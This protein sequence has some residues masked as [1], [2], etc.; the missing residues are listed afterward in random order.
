MI[1]LY[2]RI[3]TPLCKFAALFIGFALISACARTEIGTRA[4][5]Y[6]SALS[7]YGNRE[8]LLNAVRASK[9]LPM[10]F[11][12]IGQLTANEVVDGSIGGD[13]PFVAGKLPD[14]TISPGFNISSGISN[15]AVSNLNQ[16][17]FWTRMTT[18]LNPD[19]MFYYLGNGWRK[20]LIFNLFLDR[21]TIEQ[22]NL[23]GLDSRVTQICSDRRKL[24]QYD[25]RLCDHI[26]S[27]EM[28]IRN[29]I[30]SG[31]CR[32]YSIKRTIEGEKKIRKTFFSFNNS[33]RNACTLIRYQTLV[34]KFLVLD[35][36]FRIVP[37]KV[38][39]KV[40]KIVEKKE[41]IPS[42]KGEVELS[43]IIKTIKEPSRKANTYSLKFFPAP[44]RIEFDLD[45]NELSPGSDNTS[46]NL[47]I[48]SPESMLFYLGELIDLQTYQN[49]SYTPGIAIAESAK[50]L[51]YF[52]VHRGATIRKK[53]SIRLVHEGEHFYIP[54]PD[55]GNSGA[56]RTHQVLTL[57][58]QIIS[59]LTKSESIPK[60][61]TLTFSN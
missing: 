7:D 21:I 39:E 6:N 52:V 2:G 54:R 61:S 37:G 26:D 27:E 59:L 41:V 24:D 46:Q 20:E 55:Y 5:E 47:S 30:G 43:K 48:R 9:R 51:P 8:I 16:E 18:E 44:K 36:E 3:N 23:N 50:L 60:S 38:D 13:L 22:S 33:G 42:G 10:Y 45:E 15:F 17:D 11:S 56:H 49:S 29:A 53:S 19:L 28:Y 14:F 32:K 31:K 12:S 57:I 1:C 35:P 58:H 25:E 34:R 40:L 4:T